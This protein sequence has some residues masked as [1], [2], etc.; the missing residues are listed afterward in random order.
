LLP[1]T[2]TEPEQ[3]AALA[4]IHLFNWGSTIS[5]GAVAGDIPGL[6]FGAQR[7]AA[8]LARDLFV[9]DE[10]LHDARLR[11]HDEQELRYTTLWGGAP[12]AGP[13]LG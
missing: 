11:A 8:A 5:Q 10:R 4:R 12:G 6:A 13:R 3:A 7:L 1:R 2:G 9:E